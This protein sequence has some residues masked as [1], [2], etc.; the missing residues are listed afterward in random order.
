MTKPAGW[1]WRQDAT[2]V[3]ITVVYLFFLI[4]AVTSGPRSQLAIL[5]YFAGGVYGVS[6]I[7]LGFDKLTGGRKR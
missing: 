4:L 3:L 7:C 6:I 5:L 2:I 1:T